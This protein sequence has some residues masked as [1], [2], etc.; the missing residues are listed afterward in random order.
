MRCIIK[1]SVIALA[2]A[3]SSAPRADALPGQT[4]DEVASWMQAHPT[5]RPGRGERLT[6]RKGDRA[7]QRF[8]FEAS[9]LS[10]GRIASETSGLIRSER[11]E[12]YDAI[13]GVSAERLVE[14]LRIIYGVDIYQD[15]QRARVLY[16]Y[17]TVAQIARARNEKRPLLYQVG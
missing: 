8:V 3:L 1:W 16:T 12:F 15:Y 11:L 10:P 17:P 5:L 14:S 2:I 7:A 13:E 9:V 4:T 6:V